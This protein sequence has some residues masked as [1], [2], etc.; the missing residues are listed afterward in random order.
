MSLFDEPQE[1]PGDA[2][3]DLVGK[4]ADYE[5]LM[6]GLYVVKVVDTNPQRGVVRIQSA[7]L[8]KLSSLIIDE[9]VHPSQLKWMR[10]PAIWEVSL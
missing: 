3:A 10:S 2:L 5:V 7:S 4:Y 9:W 8:S 1:K 6:K